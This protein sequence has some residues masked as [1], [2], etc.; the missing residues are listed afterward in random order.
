MNKWIDQLFDAYFKLDPS[1]HFIKISG[2]TPDLFAVQ[3]EALL[4][5][6]IWEIKPE[7]VDTEFHQKIH[8][9]QD[10]GKVVRVSG[11][12]LPG[13]SWIEMAIRPMSDGIECYIRDVAAHQQEQRGPTH[14]E[15]SRILFDALLT[16]IPEVIMIAD[17]QEYSFL[18]VS[19]HTAKILAVPL[20]TLLD[21]NLRDLLNCVQF[22]KPDSPTPLTIDEHPLTQF[23][24]HGI[25]VEDEEYDLVNAAGERYTIS[26][27]GGP[28]CN[29]DGQIIAGILSWMDITQRKQQQEELSVLAKNLHQSNRDLEDFAYTVAHDLQS[30]VR[31]MLHFSKFLIDKYS[32]NIPEDGRDLLS[33]VHSSALRMESLTREILAYSQL[34]Q[35]PVNNSVSDLNEVVGQVIDDLYVMINQGN[36][37]VEVGPLP[38]VRAN[39]IHMHQLFLNLISNGIKFS[40]EGVAPVVRVNISRPFQKDGD[41]WVQITVEDNG[42]GFQEEDFDKILQPLVRLHGKNQLDGHGLGLAICK[43]ILDRLGGEIEASSTPCKGSTIFIT[44]PQHLNS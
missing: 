36:A 40:R 30:P 42:I 17:A 28:V 21:Y 29:Q 44:L 43:R 15:N 2:K 4:G 22:F 31:K 33:R 35:L 34:N 26:I 3:P 7:L 1:W 8:Q 11:P 41:P 37:R 20:E 10:E 24:E 32:L 27:K 38:S 25:A 5:K 39:P 16:H 14:D 12:L 6:N 18:V 9:V 19:H 23:V 13:K